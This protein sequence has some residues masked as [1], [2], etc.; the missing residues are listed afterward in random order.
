MYIGDTHL[1]LVRNWCAIF[2]WVLLLFI[3]LSLRKSQKY[4]ISKYALGFLGEK[5]MI[6]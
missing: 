1:F 2:F 4:Y 5:L 3:I 6:Q